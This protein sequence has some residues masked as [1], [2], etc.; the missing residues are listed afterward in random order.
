MVVAPHVTPRAALRGGVR[1][2]P[3]AP[4]GG[5][6]PRFTPGLRFV[7]FRRV[8]VPGGYVLLGFQVGDE[9]RHRAE[10]FGH[11]IALDYWFRRPEQVAEGLIAAGLAMRA[12]TVREPDD[13]GVEKVR[14]AFLLA[15]RPN[16]R[17]NP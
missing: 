13:D 3:V 17:I 10:A 9:Q 15:N 5:R 12:T 16:S 7:E 4:D 11:T 2:R 1:H 14:R 8:L 6:R